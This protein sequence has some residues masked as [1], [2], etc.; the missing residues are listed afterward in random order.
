M[1]KP[2]CFITICLLNTQS[3]AD[4][5]VDLT[6]KIHKNCKY[7]CN[8]QTLND[9]IQTYLLTNIN[10]K[11]DNSP[12]DYDYLSAFEDERFIIYLRPKARMTKHNPPFI[13]VLNKQ[14]ELYLENV[15]KNK[16]K[17]IFEAAKSITVE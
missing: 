13:L 5:Y 1:I 9:E 8:Y 3:M 11:T 14:F 2:L 6:Q 15:K 16:I 10:F 7:I 17:T 12:E 4:Y